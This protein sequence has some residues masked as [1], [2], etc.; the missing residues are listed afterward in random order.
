MNNKQ[1]ELIGES[2]WNTYKRIGFVLGEEWRP[3][4]EPPTPRTD[5]QIKAD[6]DETDRLA[7]LNPTKKIIS[8]PRSRKKKPKK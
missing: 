3:P 8:L 4:E 5:A 6:K 7:A 1:Y 2:I